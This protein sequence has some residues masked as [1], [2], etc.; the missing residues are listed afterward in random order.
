[1]FWEKNTDICVYPL[2]VS[3]PKKENGDKYSQYE[4]DVQKAINNKNREK[5]EDDLVGFGLSFVKVI[6]GYPEEGNESEMIEEQTFFVLNYDI[7][8]KAPISINDFVDIG[9]FLCNCYNQDSVLI[10]DTET[11]KPTYY[12]KKGNIVGTFNGKVINDMQ[13][14]YYTCFQKSTKGKNKEYNGKDWRF[15]YVEDLRRPTY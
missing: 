12:N 4:R 15:T 1:M 6:G 14:I 11:S 8:K 2:T 3:C 7:H 10:Y 5:L 9:I 13:S